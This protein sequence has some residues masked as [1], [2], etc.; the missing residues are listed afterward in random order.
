MS[1]SDKGFE[2]SLDQ[3]R[4]EHQVHPMLRLIEHRP[5]PPRPGMEEQL[6][7]LFRMLRSMTGFSQAGPQPISFR[8]LVQMLDEYRLTS[9]TRRMALRYIPLMDGAY[10][11][12]I[13]AGSAPKTKEYDPATEA[14]NVLVDN[15]RWL[16][17]E[18][19]VDPMDMTLDV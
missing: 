19:D 14:L 10:R 11:R 1:L 18:W 9:E 5:P 12:M 16:Q 8:D 7:S 3:A 4:R 13:S 15:G 2:E 17:D 6:V